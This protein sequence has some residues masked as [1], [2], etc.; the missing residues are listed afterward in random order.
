MLRYDAYDQAIVI[1]GFE[2]GIADSPY[3]GLADM[4]NM[5][6]ISIP[7][8]GSVNF[9]TASMTIPPATGTVDFSIDTTTDVFT[10]P[11]TSGWY[12]GMAVAM[13]TYHVSTGLTSDRTYW[14]GGVGTGTFQIYVSPSLAT[15]VN[16]GGSNG[17][18]SITVTVMGKPLD[19]AIYFTDSTSRRPYAFILDDAGRAWWNKNNGGTATNVWVYLGNDTLTGTTGRAITTFHDYLVV[20]RT[21]STD[22]LALASLENGT[23]LDSGSG[24]VYGWE[25]VTT[26]PSNPRAVLV[27]QDNAL[28]YNNGQSRLGSIVPVGSLFD[29]NDTSTYTK[30]TTA[31][32]L[33]DSDNV[34]SLA[35]LGTSLM[36]GG[37][38]NY[39][40]PWDRVST[41]FSYPILLSESY[42]QR[43]VT[44]NT[45][46]YIFVGN[47]GRIYLTNGT[48]AKL[49]TKIPDHI[50]GTVEPVFTWG[51]ATF[52]KNQ[53]YFTFTART[54]T[55]TVLTQYGGIWAV[56]LNSTAVRLENK[57][58][59]NTYGGTISIVL[60]VPAGVTL[61]TYNTD[62]IAGWDNTDYGI[63]QV[64]NTP[65]T[66]FETTVDSDLIPIGT[67]KKPRQASRIEYKLSNPMVSGESVTLKYRTDFSQTYATIMVDSTVGHFSN[68]E[69]L[70]FGNAQWLQIRAVLNSTA[71]SPSYTRL[72]QIRITGVGTPQSEG[73]QT[74][75]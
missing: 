48:Q 9:S 21:S 41:S 43:M 33:P 8:E 42:I 39:I 14:V 36:I 31:L 22:Y 1:D 12:N 4:R 55:G 62:L 16:V 52:N 73:Q 72:R 10:V 75:I 44:V 34:V 3:N 68:D 40:Y 50:S 19:K 27:A 25:S 49:Y 63:D 35:E 11:D 13:G 60:G 69:S 58:S 61:G 24:W 37:M 46:T 18:G 15:P 45:N 74:S 17:T 64:I 57:P 65:Y 28:Y 66:N 26:V 7:G 6:I 71:S 59:Y 51:D 5:N 29:P 23:D 38:R 53:L 32:D 2:N 30:N 54:R 70:N 56:D 47:R 20:F 67:F